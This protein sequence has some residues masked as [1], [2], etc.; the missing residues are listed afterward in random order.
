MGTTLPEGVQRGAGPDGLST[1]PDGGLSGRADAMTIRAMRPA[2]VAR[3]A[4]LEAASF[5][6]PWRASTFATLLDRPGAELLV[7][8]HD[9]AGVIGYAVLWCILDQG[10]LANIAIDRAWR[11]RGLGSRLLARALK[12]ARDRG[13]EVVY[14]EV[15]ESNDAAQRMY[16]R[17]GFTQVA[18]RRGYYERPREDARV[19]MKRLEGRRSAAEARAR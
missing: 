2:D 4:E 6:T 17:F 7:V 10:E 13:V 19:M 14:L 1:R 12:V 9:D 18:V 5:S 16:R 8:E 11:G 15:R 3:V